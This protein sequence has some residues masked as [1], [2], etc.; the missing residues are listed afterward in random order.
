MEYDQ[1]L[2]LLKDSPDEIEFDDV[3]ELIDELY[4]FAPVEFRNGDLVN[5]AGQGSGSCKLFAF[6][7]LL[8]LNEQQTLYCF[9]SYYRDD[10]L[11]HPGNMDHPNIRNFMKSG[12]QGI[13]FEAVPLKLKD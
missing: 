11:K 6:A 2:R 10:V 4:E 7:K 13:E 8:R 5:Q 3:V 12:W 1:L 9:G